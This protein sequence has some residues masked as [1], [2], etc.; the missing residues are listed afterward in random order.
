MDWTLQAPATKKYR[1]YGRKDIDQIAGLQRLP[2]EQRDILKAVS[3]VLPFR[4]NNYVIDEL[5]DWSRLP[6]DPMYQLTFPQPGMLSEEHLNRVL[7][8][9]QNGA[10]DRTIMEVVRPIQMELNPHPAGQKQ[11]NVPKDAGN[12]MQGLQHKYRETVLFFPA[13][14]QTCHA[15]CTYCFRWAQFVGIDDLKFATTEALKLANYLRKNREVSDVLVTGG[16][17]MIMKTKVLRRYLEPL[18][19]PEMDSVQSI[20]IGTKAPAYWPFRFTLDRDADDLMRLFEEIVAAGKH[21]AIMAHFSHPRELETPAAQDALRR[22]R[23]TG[24]VIRCQAPLIRHVNDDPHVWSTMW[25]TQVS[26]GCIPYYM[27]VERDTGPKKY[28]EVPLAR[29]FQ[30]FTEAYNSVSGLARTVRGPSMSALPGKVLVDGVIDL[31]QGRY[32][33]LKFIQGRSSDWVNKPFLAEYDPKA[34]W[35]NDLKP[36]FGEQEFFFEPELAT[37]KPRGSSYETAV[38]AE[39][40]AAPA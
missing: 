32:F 7:P 37:L 31:P 26:Q 34:T 6:D 21:L 27:F 4:V 13:Q 15:Y 28:F 20:R 8:L 1:A 19:Q 22:I 29:A 35:L 14:G 17:P 18:L 11:W 39:G 12:S 36:A 5:I 2:Q 9:V 30:I 23:S 40:S 10:D 38:M 24:A 25:R 16:D 3:Y 33:V